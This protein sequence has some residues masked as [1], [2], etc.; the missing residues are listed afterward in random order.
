MKPGMTTKGLKKG[1]IT[2]LS[3]TETGGCALRNGSQTTTKF[4]SAKFSLALGPNFQFKVNGKVT[5][6]VVLSLSLTILKRMRKAKKNLLQL[7]WTQMTN[8]ST[9][10]NID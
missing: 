7:C 5:L 4:T 8:G 10:H 6:L 3:M 1:L 9:I 2:H